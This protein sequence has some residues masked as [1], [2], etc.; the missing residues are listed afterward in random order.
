MCKTLA[1]HDVEQLAPKSAVY[2][3]D[4][5]RTLHQDTPLPALVD[6]TVEATPDVT[7]ATYQMPSPTHDPTDESTNMIVETRI[8]SDNV[9]ADYLDTTPKLLTPKH[10]VDNMC[11]LRHANWW[12][13][14][15]VRQQT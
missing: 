2:D 13:D 7:E 10:T 12:C 3:S 14:F 1:E 11:E 15:D 8:V 9:A 4:P 6:T 5:R